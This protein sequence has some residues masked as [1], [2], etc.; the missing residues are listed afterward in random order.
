MSF[1]VVT[2]KLPDNVNLL[3]DKFLFL[4]DSNGRKG[5]IKKQK[6][7]ILKN[8]EKIL[9][10]SS[11]LTNYT[12]ISDTIGEVIN[13]ILLAEFE[14][15]DNNITI[16]HTYDYSDSLMRNKIILKIKI[17]VI[18][19]MILISKNIIIDTENKLKKLLQRN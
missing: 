19:R 18:K 1:K 3:I 10:L 14:A 12:T 4:G 7:K 8:R 6:I 9:K 17:C 11:K 13:D 5:Y 2:N 15:I 16:D